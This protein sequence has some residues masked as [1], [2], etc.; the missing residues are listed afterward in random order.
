MKKGR[1]RKVRGRAQMLISK[2]TLLSSAHS[3]V[4]R[5]V[6]LVCAR[7][8]TAHGHMAQAQA[9]KVAARIFKKSATDGSS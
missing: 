2:T 9:C 8:G 1:E 5:R 6:V 3:G 4:A 7:L